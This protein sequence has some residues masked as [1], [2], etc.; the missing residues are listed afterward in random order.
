M[1]CRLNRKSYARLIQED[2]EW[3]MKQPRTLE[4]DHI[5]MILKWSINELYGVD[6]KE[7]EQ[8]EV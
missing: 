2:I 6:K 1:G 7:S 5:K 4:R 8:K 3:L